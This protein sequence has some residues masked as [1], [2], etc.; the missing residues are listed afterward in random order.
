MGGAERQILLLT[1]YLANCQNM[2]IHILG[3]SAPGRMVE[4]CEQKGIPCHYLPLEWPRNRQEWVSSISQLIR[5][6]RR[7]SGDIIMPYGMFP[8]IFC[9]LSW[10]L[11]GARL[12]VWNQRNEGRYLTGRLIER[13]AVRLTP[14]FI[15][16][17]HHGA[18]F[19]IQTYGINKRFVKV[20]PN[21]V[22]LQKPELDA[23]SWRQ[24]LAI[25]P[26]DLV[27]CMVANLH[28]FKDQATLLKAWRLVVNC[29]QSERRQAFLLLAG[30]FGNTTDM[31]KALA[32]DLELGQQVRFLGHVDDIAGLLAASDL[33]VFSSQTE[34]L[35][36]GVLECM[37]AGLPVVATDIPGIR[38][39][40]GQEE[41]NCLAPPGNAEQLAETILLIAQNEDLRLRLSQ[42]NQERIRL[43]F[44]P[45]RMCE[46]TERLLLDWV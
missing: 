33:G 22:R 19:L 16:N 43:A 1:D 42:Q 40:F 26:N 21:G 9:G 20:I 6:F 8:N 23:L 35:P 25:G 34:G 32:Y 24:K 3:F 38:E 41:T 2:D 18:R 5:T 12:C 17:S 45:Q 27:A 29:F 46:Q 31:L 7:V 28:R 44:N 36:N 37:A 10:R 11:S 13:L 30:R 15:S 39:V 14:R 4:L